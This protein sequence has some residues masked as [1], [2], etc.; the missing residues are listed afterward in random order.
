MSAPRAVHADA[1]RRAHE[2]AQALTEED[3]AFAVRSTRELV[4]E[5]I[6]AELPRFVAALRQADAAG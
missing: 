4:F 6:D 3:R 1:M 5:Q 2:E